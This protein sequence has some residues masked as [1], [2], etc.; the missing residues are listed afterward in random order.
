MSA[1]TP[2]LAD[3]GHAM[4]LPAMVPSTRDSV[5]I[6]ELAGRQRHVDSTR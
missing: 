6:D 1:F 3:E 4:R 2:P 5:P